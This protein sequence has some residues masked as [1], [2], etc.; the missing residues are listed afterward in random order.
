M[1]GPP[2]RG[3]FPVHPRW[4]H[5]GLW[6]HVSSSVNLAMPGRL[7]HR[8]WPLNPPV[9]N[10]SEGH[11]LCHIPPRRLTV[12]AHL[13]RIANPGL[14]DPCRMPGGQLNKNLEAQPSKASSTRE[15]IASRGSPAGSIGERDLTAGH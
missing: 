7:P 2:H 14:G 3:L 13:M 1:G 8:A 6:L 11:L 5:Y 10:Y 15:G 9:V 4:R 12:R